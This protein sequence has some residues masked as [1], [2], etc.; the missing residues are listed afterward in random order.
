MKRS[1][2][3]S[4]IALSGLLAASLVACAP[5]PAPEEQREAASCSQT[6]YMK[7]RSEL[8]DWWS[9]SSLPITW[10]SKVERNSDFDG[11]T[12]PDHKPP[13]GYQGLVQTVESGTH[14]Q[15]VEYSATCVYPPIEGG[16]GF[17][18]GDRRTIQLT[19]TVTIDGQTIELSTIQYA[20]ADTGSPRPY[21][22]VNGQQKYYECGETMTYYYKTPRGDL[23]YSEYLECTNNNS[24]NYNPVMV[25]KNYSR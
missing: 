24:F 5:Q 1:I 10:K 22:T 15:P 23:Q 19:P 4:G 11:V 13:Q 6:V 9:G 7:T 20:N 25:I 16:G 3:V 17:G 8:R 14:T 18:A 12:R 2:Q 21:Y